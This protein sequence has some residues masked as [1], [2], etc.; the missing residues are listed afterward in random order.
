MQRAY[1]SCDLRWLRCLSYVDTTED[2]FPCRHK[3]L[4]VLWAPIRCGLSTLEIGVEIAA[5]QKSPWN[6]DRLLRSREGGGY[7]ENGQNVRGVEILRHRA[8]LL[9]KSCRYWPFLNKSCAHMH[10]N[11]KEFWMEQFSSV[12][13]HDLLCKR[14]LAS[15]TTNFQHQHSTQSRNW[16][17][18]SF[19]WYPP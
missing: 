4:S 14:I 17:M 1:Y 10:V 15:F 2:S 11:R 19:S 3:T 7:F 6:P 8:G 12:L 13:S 18:P 9:C 16:C 5:L